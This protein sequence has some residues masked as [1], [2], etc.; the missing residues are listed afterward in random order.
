MEIERTLFQMTDRTV[1][2]IIFMNQELFGGV[3]GSS[4]PSSINFVELH[5]REKRGAFGHLVKTAHFKFDNPG[6]ENL[7]TKAQE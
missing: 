3:N 1:V 5:T 7:M 6:A 4:F 2:P